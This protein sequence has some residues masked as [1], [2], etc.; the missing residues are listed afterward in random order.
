MKFTALDKLRDRIP[1][2]SRFWIAFIFFGQGVC[3]IAFAG[4]V[5]IPP[6]EV[7]TPILVLFLGGLCTLFFFKVG[8]SGRWAQWQRVIPVFFYGLFICLMSS[9]SLAGVDVGY[10]VSFFFHPVEY[11]TLGLLLGWLWYP[12]IDQKGFGSFALRVIIAGAVFGCADEIH[13]AFVPGRDADVGDW[14]FDMAGI[15]LSV[16]IIAAIRHLMRPHLT[17]NQRASG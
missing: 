1:L 16:L 17:N 2:D 8:A 12:V 9:R 4:I 6:A 3:S 7:F 10:D 14:M 15:G 11:M 13:Q 5:K